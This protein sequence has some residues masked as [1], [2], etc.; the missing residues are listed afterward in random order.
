MRKIIYCFNQTLRKEIKKSRL[1][2]NEW[3]AYKLYTLSKF[4][5]KQVWQSLDSSEDVKRIIDHYFRRSGALLCDVYRGW[6]FVCRGLIICFH[7]YTATTFVGSSGIWARTFGFLDRRSAPW[8]VESTE[9]GG[10]S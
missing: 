10:E 7:S 5:G 1:G 6:N 8:A 4:F 9:I 2:S 3:L